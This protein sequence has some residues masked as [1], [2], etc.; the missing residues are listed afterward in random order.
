M[1]KCTYASLFLML[2]VACSGFAQNKCATV[3]GIGQVHLLDFGNPDWQ[4]GRPTDA[5]V[6]PVQ[7]AVGKDQ[8]FV[9]KVS[10]YD[11]EPGPSNHTGQG[12]DTGSFYFIFPEG[13][14]TVRYTHAVWPTFPKFQAAFTGTFH[15]E[16]SVDVTA[17]TGRFAHTTGNLTADGPFL[18]WNLDQ[19]FP[20]GRFI[21]T[22]HGMLCNI[23]SQ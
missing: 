10:E 17:G 20:S 2:L 4:G 8:V 15:T 5:W 1:K 22:F 7:L 13:T 23:A 19:L 6:G 14:L 12:V 21:P 9:G 16:G 11:G 18:V 3:Q